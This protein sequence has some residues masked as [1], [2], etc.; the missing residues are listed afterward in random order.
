MVSRKVRGNHSDQEASKMSD[1]AAIMVSHRGKVN[2]IA[3]WPFAL[4]LTVILALEI[5]SWQ[6]PSTVWSFRWHGALA[7]ASLQAR[8]RRIVLG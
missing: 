5:G 8:W 2:G 3:F 4:E 7:P 1:L 6:T